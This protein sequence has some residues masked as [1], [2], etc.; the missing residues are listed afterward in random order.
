MEMTGVAGCRCGPPRMES[1]NSSTLSPPIAGQNKLVIRR[2]VRHALGA[3]SWVAAARGSDWPPR[4]STERASELIPDHTHGLQPSACLRDASCRR[5]LENN[6]AD[7]LT[8]F[9]DSSLVK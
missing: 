6:N 2:V 4:C 9:A 1:N 8:K 5:A 7:A 3:R